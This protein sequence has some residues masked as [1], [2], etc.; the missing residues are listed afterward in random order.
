MTTGLVKREEKW[1]RPPAKPELLGLA[2]FD[3]VL[4]HSINA[5]GNASTHPIALRLK[6]SISVVCLLPVSQ[7]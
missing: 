5:F 4:L 6:G 2:R 7:Q 3:K 1:M